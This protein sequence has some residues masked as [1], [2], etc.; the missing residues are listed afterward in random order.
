MAKKQLVPQ[1]LQ[2]FLDVFVAVSGTPKRD[3]KNFVEELIELRKEEGHAIHDVGFLSRK[4]F[5]KERRN[6]HSLSTAGCFYKPGLLSYK[7]KTE[8]HQWLLDEGKAR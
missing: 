4:E 5:A 6:W 1:S 8:L 3:D 7:T 2:L